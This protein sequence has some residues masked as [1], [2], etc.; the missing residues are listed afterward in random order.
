MGGIPPTPVRGMGGIPPFVY[1]G[2]SFY[3]PNFMLFKGFFLE[4]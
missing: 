4:V 1:G 3:F 2:I